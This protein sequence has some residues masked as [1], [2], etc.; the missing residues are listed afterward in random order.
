MVSFDVTSLYTMITII[1]TLNIIKDYVSNDNQ[2]TR[3]KVISQ[4]KLLD[5]VKLLI[6]SFTG[7][8]LRCNGRI[9][10]QLQLK[11]ICKPI[12]ALQYL[13]YY[14]LQKIGN[15]LFMKSRQSL[16]AHIWKTFIITSKI[17][18]KTLNLL[19]TKKVMEN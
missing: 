5:L 19:W 18:I 7:I 11:S 8:L 4:D 6:L 3:K 2:F 9:S 13:W 14:T 12:D 1:D 15:Y 16:H 10:I 17:F